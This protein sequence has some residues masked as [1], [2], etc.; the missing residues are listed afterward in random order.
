MCNA[1][2]SGIVSWGCNAAAYDGAQLRNVVRRPNTG[3]TV[4]ADTAYRSKKNEVWLDKNGF[5]SNIH[6]KKP[7][8]RPMS[9][10]TARANGRRFKIRAHIEHVI[11]RQKA[12]MGLFVRTIGI[13]RATMKIGMANIAYNITRY[14]WH[15]KRAASV[16]RAAG[17]RPLSPYEIQHRHHITASVS[18]EDHPLRQPLPVIR[19]VHLSASQFSFGLHAYL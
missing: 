5:A 13:A 4:W 6:R 12:R 10:A 14:G 16:S 18:G 11:A 1:R 15:E 8:G 7:K 17:R 9:E 19:A 3:S 2:A